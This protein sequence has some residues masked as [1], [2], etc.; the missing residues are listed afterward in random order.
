M[1]LVKSD[2]SSYQPSILIKFIYRMFDIIVGLCGCIVTVFLSIIV[3]ISYIKDHDYNPI[4]F[5][6]E[7]IGKDGKLFKM[8]KFRT[9]VPNADEIL[10][11]LMES[12]EKIKQEYETNKKL[13]NDPRITK[14]GHKLRK[15]SLDEFPQFLNVLKGEMTLVGPRPYLV[16]EIKDMGDT[17][18]TI[19]QCKP[20]ITGPWQVGGRSDI[21]F[22]DRCQIDVKYVNEKNIKNDLKIFMR[23]IRSVIKREGAK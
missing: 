20:A 5:I 18:N 8:Y 6:Q 10:Y 22:N 16:R 15:S 14:L 4:I 11:E 21:D 2:V 9:M 17:Y 1:E 7:R 3:K 23:T 19:I 13:E 12:D